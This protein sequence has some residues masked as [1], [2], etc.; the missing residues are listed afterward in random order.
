MAVMVMAMIDDGH[1][2][3]RC[4]QS[5]AQE[6]EPGNPFEHRLFATI[7]CVLMRMMV[8]V[9][10]SIRQE[11]KEDL[12]DK[13]EEHKHSC[14]GGG[15]ECLGQ[16]MEERHANDERTS[17]GHELGHVMNATLSQGMKQCAA[18]QGG[19]KKYE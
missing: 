11:F 12:D 7:V 9:L 3:Q 2:L 4:M 5:Q 10:N 15:S 19:Q 14:I 18:D 6:G 17:K 13:T 8:S 16:Q 1:A